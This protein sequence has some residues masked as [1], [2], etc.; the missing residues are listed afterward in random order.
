MRTPL[1]PALLAATLALAACSPKDAAKDCG[2]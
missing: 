2:Q 1:R